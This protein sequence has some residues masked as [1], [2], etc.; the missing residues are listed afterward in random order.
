MGGGASLRSGWTFAVS[1]LGGWA[2]G[3]WAFGGWAFGGWALGP[4]LEISTFGAGLGGS[5]LG[6]VFAAL[7]VGFD[8]GVSGFGAGFSL[9]AVLGCPFGSGG[10]AAAGSGRARDEA[11]ASRS[12]I[13]ESGSSGRVKG[14]P[15]VIGEPHWSHIEPAADIWPHQG[16]GTRSASLGGDS[17]SRFTSLALTTRDFRFRLGGGGGASSRCPPVIGEPHTWQVPPVGED[18]PHHE[19]SAAL[20]IS[21]VVDGIGVPRPRW[22]PGQRIG[23]TGRWT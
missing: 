23:T 3:G 7:T 22:C 17:S 16:Q 2:F 19:Q 9:S 15:P 1:A 5:G 11:F 10:G 20:S 13:S 21:A 6:A 12:T 14:L 4:G 8:P 18:M